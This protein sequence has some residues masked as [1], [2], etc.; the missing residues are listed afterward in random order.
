MGCTLCLCL[1][2]CLSGPVSNPEV[3]LSASGGVQGVEGDPRSSDAEADWLGAVPASPR[4]H[5]RPLS[6]LDEWERACHPELAQQR[7]RL[8]AAERARREAE[9]EKKPWYMALVPSF[10]WI[11]GW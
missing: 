11:P 2:S 8:Q 9:E 1:A 4:A 7:K 6:P 5:S 3:P 10:R